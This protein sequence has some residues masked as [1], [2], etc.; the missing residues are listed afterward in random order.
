MELPA[1]AW[2]LDS[3]LEPAVL[4]AMLE[5]YR[6]YRI[7]VNFSNGFSTRAF[8]DTVAYGNPTPL[9]KLHAF[10]PLIE[11]TARTRILDIGCHLGYYG[12]HFIAHGASFYCGI[13][14]DERL[15]DCAK[16]IRTISGMSRDRLSFIH[17]DFGDPASEIQVQRL[18]PFDVIL[19]LASL[20]N[21]LSLPAALSALAGVLAP[22]GTAV[23]EY[24][25][26]ESDE[27]ICRFHPT[28]FQGDRTH[29]WSFSEMFLDSFLAARGLVKTSRPLEWANEA[30]LGRGF[31]KI[32]SLYRRAEEGAARS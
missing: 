2:L 30:V 32:M 15:F 28:G 19:S 18:G 26:A 21:I 6:P 3:R 31:K 25:A 11:T 24:L 12:H 20:N 4:Q 1:Y 17:G 5:P 8:G 16:L 10:E 27:A 22:E 23:I 14:V 29:H 13:E 9:A 7:E